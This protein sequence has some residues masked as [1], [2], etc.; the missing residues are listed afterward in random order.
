MEK[1]DEFEN[2]E[3]ML[4]RNVISGD[5]LVLKKKEFLK[6]HILLSKRYG[7]DE[8]DGIEWNDELRHIN[9]LAAGVLKEDMLI[10]LQRLK[11]MVR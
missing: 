4:D 8:W 6:E 7:I 9:K 10:R 1:V 11:M 5:I 2:I 3:S